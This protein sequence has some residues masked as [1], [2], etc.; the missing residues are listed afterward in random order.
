[1]PIPTVNV[2]PITDNARKFIRHPSGIG[3]HDNPEGTA[4]PYDKFTMRRLRDGDI[5]IVSPQAG[6]EL[7]AGQVEQDK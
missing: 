1:M 2:R 5:E 6:P 4:W 3:F 7:L